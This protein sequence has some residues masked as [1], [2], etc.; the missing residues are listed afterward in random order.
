MIAVDIDTSSE[1]RY[2]NAILAPD[3]LV[4]AISQSGETEDTKAGIEEAKSRGL[5]VLSIVNVP[6]SA[7]TRM[8]DGTIYTN[9][10]SRKSALLRPKPTPLK[11]A[12]CICFLSA[13]ATCTD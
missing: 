8:S 2:R 1:F 13:W 3:T 4:I 9:A 6:G 12:R 11:S 5:R 10:W 7:I